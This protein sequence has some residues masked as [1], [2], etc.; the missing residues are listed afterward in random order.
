[1]KLI[2]EVEDLPPDSRPQDTALDGTALKFRTLEHGGDYPDTMP[3]A[4]EVEDPAGRKAI[5]VPFRVDGDAMA[6]RIVGR[7]PE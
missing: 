7:V 2:V 4:I 5:Y 1:M 3:Q 6:M